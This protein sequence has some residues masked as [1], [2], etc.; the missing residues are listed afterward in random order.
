MKTFLYSFLKASLFV[1]I[2]FL[3]IVPGGQELWA[4]NYNWVGSAGGDWANAANW[5]PTAVPSN[6]SVLTIGAGA[7]PTIFSAGQA[8]GTIN[9]SGTA[10]NPTYINTVNGSYALNLGYSSFSQGITGGTLY[11]GSNFNVNLMSNQFWDADQIYFSS[12]TSHAT[13]SLN[14]YNLTLGNNSSF[15]TTYVD[16]QQGK[17][18]VTGT[19]SITLTKGA[20][21]AIGGAVNTF[22]GGIL[23]KNGGVL[24]LNEGTATQGLGTGTLALQSGSTMTFGSSTNIKNNY[25]FYGSISMAGSTSNSTSPN[26]SGTGTLLQ[27]TILNLTPGVCSGLFLAEH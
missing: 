11:F 27:S 8:A 16:L 20:T 1:C 5:Q 4:A 14:S 23:V 12:S 19:G 7:S 26:F 25:S 17:T 9:V 6:N 15:S 21:L 3:N 2:C 24:D 13:L 18:L 10:S 22:S